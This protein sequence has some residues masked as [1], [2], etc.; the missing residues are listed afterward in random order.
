M[1]NPV[2]SE[3]GA[4]KPRRIALVTLFPEMFDAV[5]QFGVSS[6]AVKQGLVEVRCWN[7]REFTSDRHQTVDA[8]PYGG[9]P[10][11]VMLVQ[12]LR[13]AVQA[14]K[15]WAGEC[16]VIYLSPQGRR[17]DQ[18]AA[19]SFAA[20]PRNLVLVAGRYEGVDERFIDLEVDSEWSIGDYV[21]SGGELGAMVMIDAIARL[22]PGVLGHRQ[23][24][25]QDSFTD[26]LLDCPH[27]TRPEVYTDGAQE[28][29]VPAVLASGDHERIRRWRLQQALGRTAL[30]RPDLLQGKTLTEEQQ[31]LLTD[32]RRDLEAENRDK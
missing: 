22:I 6:R 20:A 14:A 25:E 1:A 9:G 2:E 30:R 7:P 31:R 32:F 4:K 23:S 17:F 12:P 3:S 13:D 24:A 16:E 29:P 27:F 8:R 28:L 19:Q 21:L 10:G 11:M 18:A 15:A 5:T 26:G